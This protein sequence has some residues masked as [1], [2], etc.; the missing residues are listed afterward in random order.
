[1]ACNNEKCKTEKL[2]ILYTQLSSL[3]EEKATGKLVVTSP[4]D[5]WSL[6]FLRGQLLFIVGD[7]YRVRR[8][9]R[10]IE[11]HCPYFQFNAERVANAQLWEYQILHQGIARGQLTLQQAKS[12]LSSILSEIFF[13]IVDAKEL[14]IQWQQTLKEPKSTRTFNPKTPV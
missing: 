4:K 7:R 11:Q 8:W 14:K 5:C 6:Y 3:I 12:V 10:A 9:S 13:K 1:M 2:K